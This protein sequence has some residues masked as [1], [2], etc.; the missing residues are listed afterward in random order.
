[1]I[2][3]LPH[4][5]QSWP[6]SAPG[7]HLSARELL[8]ESCKPSPSS[9]PHPVL[10]APEAPGRSQSSRQHPWL[11]APKPVN[12]PWLLLASTA[13]GSS[14]GPQSW[15]AP[16]TPGSSWSTKLPAS[17]HEFRIPAHPS[18][19]FCQGLGTSFG[20]RLP[21]SRANPGSKLRLQGVHILVGSCL[22][23]SLHSCIPSTWQTVPHR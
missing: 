3:C 22:S 17:S 14:Y 15:Q 13:P 23:C 2:A 16:L 6:T 21:A 7:N 11:Q 12:L 9:P 1:M 20:T 5:S 4:R 10:L 18:S 19:S 8:T